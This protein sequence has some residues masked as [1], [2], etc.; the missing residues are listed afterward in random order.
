AYTWWAR[1]H[2]CAAGSPQLASVS[3][4]RDRSIVGLGG[5]PSRRRARIHTN[6]LVVS[7]RPLTLEAIGIDALTIDLADRGGRHTLVVDVPRASAGP[8]GVRLRRDDSP[9]RETHV[10]TT[11]QTRVTFDGLAP[12]RWIVEHVDLDGRELH[13]LSLDDDTEKVVASKSV[14]LGGAR[15]T[16]LRLE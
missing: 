15:E 8:T 6:A 13:T 5:A 16:K 10:L 12:G 14:E 11:G 4:H 7:R 1:A 9:S 2:A 3:H